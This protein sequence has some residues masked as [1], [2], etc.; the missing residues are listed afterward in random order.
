[1]ASE[2]SAQSLDIRVDQTKTEQFINKHKTKLIVGFVAI[3]VLVSGFFGGRYWLNQREDAAQAQLALGQTY[4]QQLAQTHPDSVAT[5]KTLATTAL[6]GDGKK[7]DGFV[8]Y[9]A[10]SKDY[11][12]TDAS[13]LAHLYAGLCYYHQKD[14]KKAIEEL[15]SFSD[16]GDA[17]VTANAHKML[18]DC[19]AANKQVDDAVKEYKTAAEKA[20]SAA[21]SPLY[22]MNAAA[23]LEESGKK[24]DANKL[25]LEIKEKYPENPMCEI[26]IQGEQVNGPMI[27]KFIESTK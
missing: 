17:T 11:K 1:M 10:I 13:N 15:K 14:Y 4:I 24:A 5:V 18:A 16:K 3:L 12:W 26:G 6:K 19:Y 27:E 9:L 21:L 8:G 20:S 22:L 2:N 25:Y 7:K 23:L